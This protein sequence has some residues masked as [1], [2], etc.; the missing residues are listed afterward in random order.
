[1]L[2]PGD[3]PRQ[4]RVLPA[5]GIEIGAQ[6]G[7]DV[8]RAIPGA[9]GGMQQER[10]RHPTSAR[11]DAR[12]LRH[13]LDGQRYLYAPANPMDDAKRS[14]VHHLLDTF[15]NGSPSEA[16]LALL[17]SSGQ[18]LTKADLDDIAAAVDDLAARGVAFER[19][20]G[21][22]QDDRGILHGPGHDIAWFNDPA[23][24]NLCLVQL[25]DQPAE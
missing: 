4:L 20:P 15:F 21:F 7:H 2:V 3:P 13:R 8:H 9:L 25:H 6:R 19:Y 17:G 23:G 1:M 11:V 10:A 14:A 24:N 12:D 5:A 18:P 22:E 16:V